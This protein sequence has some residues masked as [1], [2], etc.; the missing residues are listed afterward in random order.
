VRKEAESRKQRA[1]SREQRAESREQR[2]ESREQRAE[3]REQRAESTDRVDI[4]SGGVKCL[5][6]RQ[7]EALGGLEVVGG[8]MGGG[9]DRR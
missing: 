9:G 6:T 7:G 3:S 8:G 4:V 5:S 1:E 2:A